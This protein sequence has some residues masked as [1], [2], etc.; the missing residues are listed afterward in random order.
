MS[1]LVRKE[2]RSLVPPWL[3]AMLLATVPVWLVWPG[4]TSLLA[5]D[6]GYRVYAPFALGILL[7]SL[8]PFG[9][10]LNWGTFSVLLSQ[11]VPRARIWRTK[12]LLLAGALLLVFAA[13]LISNRLRVDLAIQGAQNTEWRS[14]L[15][16]P[17]GDSQLVS[18]IAYVRHELLLGSILVGGLAALAGFAG[19]LWTPLLFRQ[20][21]AAFWFTLLV[22]M[23]LGLITGQLLGDFSN[24]VGRTVTCAVIAL[25]SIG[26]Y[27]W[28]R[29]FF[30]E[31]QDTQW[32]G[33][34]L[35][36][37]KLRAPGANARFGFR[38]RR[39]LRT[40][41]AK[42][43]QAQYV[44][45]LLAGGLLLIH[46]VVLVLR[47]LNSNYLAVH[48][49]VSMVLEAF[50][51]LWLALPLLVG[52]VAIAEERKLGTFQTAS[53]L[54]FSRRLQFAVKLGLALVL[55]VLFGALIPFGVERLGGLLGVSPTSLAFGITSFGSA[56]L[57]QNVFVACGISLLALYGSSLTNNTLQALG[58]GILACMIGALLVVVT[59]R[60]PSVGGIFLW[61]PWLLVLVLVP[62]LA[63]CI[64]AL[65]Y[66]N[67]RQLHPGAKAWLRNVVVL[68]VS[69]LVATTVTSA[70]YHRVWESWMPIEPPHD[71]RVF[72]GQTHS[73]VHPKVQTT[74]RR[75][76]VLL[77]DG[78][79]W[80]RQ[81]SI[82]LVKVVYR[83]RTFSVPQA[84]GRLRDGFVPGSD[85]RDVA[86]TEH[87][88]FAI[89]ADDSLWDLS[90]F[91]PGTDGAAS[92]LKRVG[93]SDGW[94]K[95]AAIGWHYS[96]LKSDGTLWEWGW[97]F[98]PAGQ[99]P[100]WD[101]PAPPVQVGTDNDWVAIADSFEFAVAAKAD[102]TIWRWGWIRPNWTSSQAAVLSRPTR[103]LAFPEPQRPVSMSI[104]GPALAAVCAD[105]TLWVGGN[106]LYG[107]LDAKAQER[108]TTEMV[109]I[110]SDSDWRQVELSG[111]PRGVVLKEN[112][113]IF[114]WD[115][116]AT[117]FPHASGE[118]LIPLSRMSRYPVWTSIGSYRNAFLA[119]GRDDTLCLWGDPEPGPY[120]D[121]T[122]PDPNRL[123]M[124]SRIHARRI[125]RLER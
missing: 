85:W 79:L 97:H 19:G 37:P 73:L 4:G 75:M 87:N 36:I 66:S 47:A 13:F 65:S 90:A 38:G 8:T 44:N 60:P 10:E 34:V 68:L 116:A 29:N 21:S 70:V 16:R 49:S 106:F 55:G 78:R 111:T 5:A 103:W 51:V 101:N 124:P 86:L 74:T 76:A 26:G 88:C 119:L 20:V 117:G 3:L 109:Q 17:G 108:A 56:A 31:V 6:L 121:P 113:A 84:T 35:S 64:L 91:E 123:L 57:A 89:R 67:Y 80:L 61:G 45:L 15:D 54:P 125:A 7:L 59:T 22:P 92:G 94:S 105:G 104:N 110:G 50:P 77:P 100:S 14:L 71:Y 43:L 24:P 53:C 62:I 52:T 41:L 23:G 63:V 72:Y 82:K 30:R 102:G 28:A 39:R 114:Q 48:R 9:Q 12:T 120:I 98:K 81:G 96:A 107:L 83:Q 1:A 11:P 122:H 27:V 18:M 33:G 69:L 25:Y 46:L 42:E 58:S 40:L 32:T 115:L 112:G 2:V 93:D 95:L 118:M 99:F